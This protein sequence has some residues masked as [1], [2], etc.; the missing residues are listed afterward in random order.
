MTTTSSTRT[1]WSPRC[2]INRGLPRS[3]S[4]HNLT[5]HL[6]LITPT[7]PQARRAPG[8]HNFT[9]VCCGGGE[10]EQ[11]IRV[12]PRGATGTRRIVVVDFVICPHHRPSPEPR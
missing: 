10:E 5:P 3:I 1:L 7:H 11:F 6:S 2:T 8:G 12:T 4:I 9:E